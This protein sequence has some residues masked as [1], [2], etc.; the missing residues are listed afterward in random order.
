MSTLDERINN[1]RK[2]KKKRVIFKIISI[3]FMINVATVCII[4]TDYNMNKMLNKRSII[5]MNIEFI[6]KNIQS[7]EEIIEKNFKNFNL[8][9]K[10]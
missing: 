1:R 3:I 2:R 8:N 10:I 4:F 5:N 7:I 9:I 6:E